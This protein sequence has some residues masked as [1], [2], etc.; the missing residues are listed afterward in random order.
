MEGEQQAPDFVNRA[1]EYCK[2]CYLRLAA[3][4]LQ[5]DEIQPNFL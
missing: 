5:T 1:L 3:Q 4:F 2:T